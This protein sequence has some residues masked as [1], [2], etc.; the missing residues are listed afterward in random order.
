ML[1]HVGGEPP[2]SACFTVPATPESVGAARHRLLAT[3]R[4]WALSVDLDLVEILAQEWGV[5]HE[6]DGKYVYFVLAISD[7]DGT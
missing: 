5:K 1:R 6:A 3:L 4:G 7:R 2:R